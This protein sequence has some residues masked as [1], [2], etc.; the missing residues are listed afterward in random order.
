MD[1]RDDDIQFDFFDDEPATSETAQTSRVRLPRRGGSNGNGGAR[2]LGPPRRPS[3][4]L[5]LL[6]IVAA[7]VGLILLF[8]ILINSCAGESRKDSYSNYMQDV[9][10]IATQSTAN[11][12]RF[13]SAL[14]TPGISA[15]Q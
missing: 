2:T 15:T 4:L 7:V 6:G 1:P 5:K 9:Q 13:A 11:G 14:T 3:P 10:Q 8:G 12:K